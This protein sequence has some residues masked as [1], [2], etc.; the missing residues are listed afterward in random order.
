MEDIAKAEEVRKFPTLYDKEC[1]NTTEKILK[2]AGVSRYTPKTC[3]FT[4]RKIRRIHFAV[5]GRSL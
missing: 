2:K 3:N 5:C 1:K 4:S